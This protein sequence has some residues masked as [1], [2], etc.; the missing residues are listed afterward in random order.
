MPNLYTPSIPEITAR[1][2]PVVMNDQM[3]VTLKSTGPQVTRIKY[4]E[5]P[6]GL[7]FRENGTT[8]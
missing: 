6:I 8:Y 7:G 3:V 4:T 2:T 5:L 1:K